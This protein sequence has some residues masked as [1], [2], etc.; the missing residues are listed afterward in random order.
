MGR[1][2]ETNKNLAELENILANSV[3]DATDIKTAIAM[4]L[5]AKVSVNT[6]IAKSLAQ[7]ADDIQFLRETMAKEQEEK[8][9]PT[10][11]E[12]KYSGMMNY[13][14]KDDI[15]ETDVEWCNR[16][17]QKIDFDDRPDCNY[18]KPVEAES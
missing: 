17:H 2:E 12:C 8:S 9:K 7:L 5:T 16:K 4:I 18:F 6:E 3:N 14:N 10:C 1:V 15:L 11:L 13:V